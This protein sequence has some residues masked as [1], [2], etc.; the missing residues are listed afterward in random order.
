MLGR[1]W[2]DRSHLL[3]GGCPHALQ[4][5]IL[6]VSFQQHRLTCTTEEILSSLSVVSQSA[7][8]N[9]VMVQ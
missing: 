1:V 3:Q 6:S 5:I 8:Q 2:S 7:L 9:L 4:L